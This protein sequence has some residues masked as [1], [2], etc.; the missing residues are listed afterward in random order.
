MELLAGATTEDELFTR[1]LDLAVQELSPE[2]AAVLFGGEGELEGLETRASFGFNEPDRLV[3]SDEISK[4][5]LRHV[6]N[7]G[8]PVMLMD[9]SEDPEYAHRQSVSLAGIRSVVCVSL[10]DGDGD[11][12]GLIY[13]DDRAKRSAFLDEKLVW[14]LRLAE[15]VEGRLSNLAGRAP[16]NGA[17]AK[18]EEEQPSK[19][20]EQHHV[21]GRALLKAG[22][23]RKAESEFEKA[24][25][26]ATESEGEV[27][28][29]VATVLRSTAKLYRVQHRL[30]ESLHLLDRA[31]N[32]FGDLGDEA[33]MARCLNTM[34]VGYYSEAEYGEATRLFKKAL[35]LWQDKDVYHR[36][37][38]SALTRMGDIKRKLGDEN[39]AKH[40]YTKAFNKCK[41]VFGEHDVS[42]RKARM[43]LKRVGG[44][45]E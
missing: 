5:P 43:R 16:T 9:A 1:A 42:T 13:C 35:K 33:E 25:K 6:L 32:I 18:P 10:M 44:T 36:L 27:S 11:V 40:Y 2:R 39:K 3:V 26:S 8:E 31:A 20:W 38:S 14:M 28:L 30:D 34:A 12:V 15:A 4:Q 45:E 21:R 19:G 37:Q 41:N 22:E 24:L 7:D 23:A 29:A 17:A